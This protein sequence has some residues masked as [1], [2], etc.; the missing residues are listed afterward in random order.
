MAAFYVQ[1]PSLEEVRSY[2][3]L[4]SAHGNILLKFPLRP[5]APHHC[6]SQILPRQGPSRVTTSIPEQEAQILKICPP[7]PESNG[8]FCVSSRWVLWRA[9]GSCSSWVTGWLCG[10]GTSWVP[11]HTH[12][13]SIISLSVT[14]DESSGP[15]SQC[16]VSG[17]N[18]PARWHG[19]RPS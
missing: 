6:G 14:W 5:C 12:T 11:T 13:H 16:Y 15:T 19:L 10:H 8:R 4:D 18:R 7:V 2:V 17:E 9:R 1:R 3:L